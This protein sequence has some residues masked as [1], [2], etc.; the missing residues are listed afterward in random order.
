MRRLLAALAL[1]VL[2][3]DCVSPQPSPTPQPSAT[4]PPSP[5]S[6]PIATATATAIP[7]ATPS[8][9]RN[10]VGDCISFADVY[11]WLDLDGDGQQGTEEPPLPGVSILITGVGSTTVITD[12]TGEAH[13]APMYGCPP[14]RDLVAI[15]TP[16]PGYRLTTPERMTTP[17]RT[18]ATPQFVRFGFAKDTTIPTPTVFIHADCI[19]FVD[20]YA[21][22]DLDGDGQPGTDEPPL[23]GISVLI[24]GYG[25]ITRTTDD[26]GE[27]QYGIIGSCPEPELMATANLPAG[28][29]LTTPGRVTV[30]R[31]T[32]LTPKYAR[33]GFAKDA[34]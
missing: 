3:T 10:V 8:P 32:S 4:L 11:T 6:V 24:E 2:L 22:Q 18:S 34:P 28:Y 30:P 25:S 5:T 13:Y 9:T 26:K 23:P 15:A 20:I 12:A 31:R 27:I 21:W 16:P 1:L 7:V 29:H 33:F 19:A 14:W 17:V